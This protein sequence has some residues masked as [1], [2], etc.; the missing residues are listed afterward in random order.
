MGEL[1]VIAVR[2]DRT[3]ELLRACAWTCA[4]AGVEQQ[5]HWLSGAREAY[6]KG[7]FVQ[8]WKLAQAVSPTCPMCVRPCS[9]VLCH[10]QTQRALTVSLPCCVSHRVC[11][12]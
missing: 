1:C 11:C 3:A 7:D 8:S 5:Q 10:E 12:T 9:A 4:G 6:S 2:V